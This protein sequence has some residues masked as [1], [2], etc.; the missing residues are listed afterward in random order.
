MGRIRR[1]LIGV[2]IV[3]AV[4]VLTPLAL[5]VWASNRDLGRYQAQIAEQVRRATGRE[6]AMRGP[7]RINFTWSPSAIAE[8]VT[9]A[10]APGGT[11]PEMARVRRVVLHLD[12]VSLLLGEIRVGR[13]NLDGADILIE[14]D[15]EGRSNVEMT[16][17]VEGSGPHPSE[18]Q[19]LRTK[20]TAS[21][22]WI[23]RIEV[24]K[25]QITLRESP[26]RPTMVV[27]I[28]RF[29]GTANSPGGAFLVDAAGSLNGSEPI[30]LKGRA[31]SFDGWLRGLPGELKLEG[32]LG[33]RALSVTGSATSKGVAVNAAMEGRSLSILTP[34]TGVPLPETA[35]FSLS[36]KMTNPRQTTRLDINELRV[37]T[38]VAR[39]D[40]T[41]RTDK[42]GRPVLVT[43]LTSERL[44]LEDLK[45][46]IVPT[47][48]AAA[49]AGP[50]IAPLAPPTP[51]VTV[52]VPADTRVVPMFQL[53]V[54]IIRRWNAS[55][56]F[57]ANAVVGAGVK[58]EALSLVIGVNNGRLVVRPAATLGG[59]QAGFDLQIDVTP[60]VPTATLN[61]STAR[62]PLD[63]IFGLLGAPQGLRELPIDLD[64]RLR[65]SGRSQRELLGVSTGAIDF[66]VGAG[67]IPA[68]A[69]GLASPDW[70][71]LMPAGT[72]NCMA[73]RF[74]VATGVAHLRRVVM[75][76]PKF[77]VGGGGFLHLRNEQLEAVLWPEPKETAL[78]A[79]A[80]PLRVKGYLGN[81]QG[82]AD[83]G[84]LKMPPGVPPGTRVGSL[85][86]AIGGGAPRPAP[87]AP[88]ASPAASCTR[89]LAQLDGLRPAMRYQLPTPPVIPVDR[90]RRPP[91]TPR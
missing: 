31:G 43:N 91:R 4:L 30:A 15:P 16:A 57:K 69:W 68:N 2:G 25:S 37:G 80:I 17:P 33:G 62:V 13:I 63:E 64:L 22:P 51:P 6:L 1:W 73:G 65:G 48:A 21:L 47:V 27:A 87:G 60:N 90:P 20:T 88:A 56:T 40:V 70:M 86:G 9:L 55:I 28:D 29:V 34:L 35:P 24:E 18:R 42:S 79:A 5:Y 10:N 71:R 14:R 39:G 78:L 77:T 74:E 45:A 46:R 76:G 84:S 8:N 12:L 82:E 58:M 3:V 66:A 85:V 32:S 36:L 26:D 61:V 72:L 50:G 54:E 11:R 81:A 49:P 44:D 59:G 19:S 75:D 41:I 67:A 53:P 52:S 89:L 23:N 7:L 83:P 38:S